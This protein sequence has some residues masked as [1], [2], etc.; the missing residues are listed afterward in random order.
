[1]IVLIIIEKIQDGAANLWGNVIFLTAVARSSIIMIEVPYKPHPCHICGK[2]VPKKDYD[3][4]GPDD[5]DICHIACFENE[6]IEQEA[7]EK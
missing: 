6:R 4:Q 2:F 7:N 3:D 1:M 5:Y